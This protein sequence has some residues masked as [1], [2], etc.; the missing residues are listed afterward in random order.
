MND[1]LS[2]R[3]M[4]VPVIIQVLFWIGVVLSVLGGVVMAAVADGAGEVLIGV[5]WIFLGPIIVRIYCEVLIVVFRINETLTD[6]K[7][8]LAQ[9]NPGQP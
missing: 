8:N 2:F 3:K 4:I 6:I 9:R 5:L 1:F 7:N